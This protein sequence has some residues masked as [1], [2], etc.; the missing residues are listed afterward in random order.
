MQQLVAETQ[1]MRQ[2]SALP[3]VNALQ[4]CAPLSR[5]VDKL[6]EK[7]T[8]IRLDR[9]KADVEAIWSKFSQ[10]RCKLGVLNSLEFRALCSAEETALRPEFIKALSRN[11]ETLRRSRCL[12]GL[13]NSYFSGWRS[14]K[15]P[16]VVER[17]LISV[18]ESYSGKN[19]V[20][21]KWLANQQLFSAKSATFLAEE[22]C[23]GQRAV[24]EVLHKYYVSP[25]VKLGLSVRATAAK[26][27]AEYFRRV[28]GNHDA[29]WS[30]GYF[31]WLTEK[32]ISDLTLPDVF[33][34]AISTLILSKSGRAEKFQAALRAYIQP[35]KRLGDPRVRETAVNWRVVAPEAK[36]QYL[37]WLARDS[38]IFFFNT[39]LPNNNENR[40]RKDFWLR[41]HGRIKD[42]QVALSEEDV[43]KV[44]SNRKISEVPYYS[45]VAHATTSAFLMNF[46]GYGGD[47]LVVEFS[48]KGNAAY[49]FKMADFSARG[50]SL[51]TSEFELTRHLKFDKT[52]RILHMSDWEPNASYQLASEFGIRP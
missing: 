46:E 29:E 52:H 3:S 13:V 38:I 12:Y 26:T 32:V 36:Q 14:M 44:K 35:N 22:I 48:E 50:L 40:R 42:F 37:S 31:H 21:Q 16:P 33:G 10:A 4:V 47:Y 17:L 24:G 49:I 7:R 8:E 15:D 45:L 9:P 2:R 28:E 19:P 20:V 30:L 43:W 6:R 41:Y 34:S 27:A 51:R 39:I 5:A 1:V 23:L 18:F 11:P 25:V